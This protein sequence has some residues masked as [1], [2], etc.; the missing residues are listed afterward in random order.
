MI[1]QTLLIEMNKVRDSAPEDTH[2]T[3]NSSNELVIYQSN[4][5]RKVIYEVARILNCMIKDH[6]KIDKLS[7]ESVS[8]TTWRLSL[9]FNS[10]EKRKS[11]LFEERYVL[12]SLFDKIDDI[13]DDID[14]YNQ[15]R[16]SV[17]RIHAKLKVSEIIQLL[18][19]DLELPRL[20]Y[21]T[22]E[23]QKFVVMLYIK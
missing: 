19:Q 4:R 9:V 23:E 14:F 5:A 17:L 7:P 11:A 3:L 1:L 12:W 16:S 15:E 10:L 21:M 8:I 13:N 20:G 6:T 22:P 18:E 2:K